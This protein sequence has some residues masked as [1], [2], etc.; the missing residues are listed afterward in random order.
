MLNNF[1]IFFL[2]D[3][4]VH[5]QSLQPNFNK[6]KSSY[7]EIYFNLVAFSLT[8]KKALW[9]RK[10]EWKYRNTDKVAKNNIC[11][12]IC[13]KI[14]FI[15]EKNV[16]FE[17]QKQITHWNCLFKLKYRPCII[18][19]YVISAWTP[20]KPKKSRRR[21]EPLFCEALPCFWQFFCKNLMKSKG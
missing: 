8:K 19:G 7:N 10:F 4:N 3:Y 15:S 12:N 2:D 20:P 14:N 6:R 11:W 13:F 9:K 1:R 21:L 16:M 5:V 18:G 17:S